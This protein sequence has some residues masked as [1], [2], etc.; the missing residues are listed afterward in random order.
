MSRIIYAL[1]LVTCCGAFVFSQQPETAVPFNPLKPQVVNKAVRWNYKV[2]TASGPLQEHEL[3]QLG[4]DGWEL[5]AISTKTD[6]AFVNVFKRV[7]F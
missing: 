7:K 1:I 6:F 3:N 2:V 4:N 5:V